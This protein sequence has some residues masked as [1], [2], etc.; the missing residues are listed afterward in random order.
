MTQT[1]LRAEQLDVATGGVPAG[2]LLNGK[3]AVSVSTNNLTVAIKT[4][5]DADPSASDPVVVR[6]GD[7]E[8]T[9]TSA[10][11]VTAAAGTN[12][13]NAGQDMLATLEVGFFVYLGYNATDGVVIGFARF[14]T[15]EKYGDF[16]TTNTDNLYCKI[17]DISNAAAADVYE[18]VGY[19]HAINSGTASYNW[20]LPGTTVTISKPTFRSH[21]LAFLPDA[22]WANM[23]M[24]NGTEQHSYMIDGDI[25]T[26]SVQLVFGTTTS[27]TGTVLLYLP[28]SPS[29]DFY[30]DVS[31]N[32]IPLK[33]CRMR[34]DSAGSTLAGAA[35]FTDS[36]GGIVLA[37]YNAASTFAT[38]SVATATVPFTWATSDEMQ[39]DYPYKYR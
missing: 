22:A 14:P 4:L 28:F 20:S 26:V 5:A 32:T 9:L 27:L 33:A 24:G 16:S 15:A 8:H 31:L 30:G 35:L 10:L 36:L 25:C 23:T 18:N 12:W 2:Y 17:S 7:V 29:R 39:F 21:N 6:I 37:A 38:Q 1:K 13:C 11:S 3:L 34:D 19:F